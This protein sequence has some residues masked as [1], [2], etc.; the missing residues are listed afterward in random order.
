MPEETLITSG[1]VER[2]GMDDGIFTI[3]N[4]G[5][6]HRR[7]IGMTIALKANE[8]KKE[9]MVQFCTA[10]CRILSQNQLGRD[11]PLG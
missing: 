9:L 8:S 11:A 7:F 4:K 10:Y 1:I 5:E 6:K 2:I 3:N